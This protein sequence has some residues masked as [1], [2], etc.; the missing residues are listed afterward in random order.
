MRWPPKSE[1]KPAWSAIGVFVASAALGTGLTGASW[2]VVAA[3][4]AVGAY[5]MLAPLVAWPPWHH[6]GESSP[7]RGITAG[8][9]IEAGRD[10]E[11]AGQIRAGHAVKAGGHVRSTRATDPVLAVVAKPNAGLAGL[12]IVNPLVG[13]VLIRQH[14]A[15]LKHG[16]DGCVFRVVLA[17]D[18]APADAELDSSIKDTLK[19]ALASSSI[20]RS[21]A[22]LGREHPASA[23]GEWE[24]VS[25]N[26]GRIATLERDWGAAEGTGS[27]L[28]GKATL[29]LP[30]HL[31]LGPR[32]LLIVDLIEQR[33]AEREDQARLRLSL[34]DLHCLLHTLAKS[35]VDDVAGTVFPAIYEDA[36]PLMFGP[37]FEIQFGDR[38]LEDLLEMA[39]G[40]TRPREARSSGWAKST[41]LKAV[42]Q[43]ILLPVTPWS[44]GGSKRFS[45]AT[46]TT[47][48][49]TRSR[50][51]P[52]PT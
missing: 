16:E 38:T 30:P 9:S 43:R 14:A 11:A 28:K 24:Q 27:T 37:S 31:M 50:N 7:S 40:F 1:D 34:S 26:T 6:A 2:P 39:P 25:P 8:H 41:C 15:S 42:T 3:L 23:R 12:G 44:A 46:N 20:E 22:A 10:I 52:A 35:I 18:Q 4:G 17:G 51:C 48:S 45:A 32:V 36:V 49:R 19:S 21:M 33:D 13:K 29:Q 47:E 5:V